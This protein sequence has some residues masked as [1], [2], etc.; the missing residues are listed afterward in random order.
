[1]EITKRIA[2]YVA[3]TDLEDF[4]PEAI[5]AA[6]GAIMDCLGCTLAGSREA[7]ADILCEFVRSNGGPDSIGAGAS[8]IGRGFKAPAPDAAL[9]NG[10]M[11]HALDYDDITQLMPTN[12]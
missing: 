7:L 8:V 9:V 12:V 11:A 10:A 1:M 5:Q 3:A 4:P 6:R 2:E